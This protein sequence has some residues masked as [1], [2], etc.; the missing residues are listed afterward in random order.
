[1]RGTSRE[2]TT[3]DITPACACSS[4][5]VAAALSCR[6]V[7]SFAIHGLEL[8]SRE[9]KTAKV[10]SLGC[11]VE[12]STASVEC[13]SIGVSPGGHTRALIALAID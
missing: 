6:P 7:N 2:C 10:V 3:S 13:A 9:T 11:F 4:S 1:M 8:R 12:L 5:L